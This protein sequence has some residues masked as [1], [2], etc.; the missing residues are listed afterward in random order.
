MD[1]SRVLTARSIW[2]FDLAEL[3]PRGRRVE[4]V[5][6]AVKSRYSFQNAALEGN[7]YI[8]KKGI[9]LIAGQEIDIDSLE[10]FDDGVVLN[11]RSDTKDSD[12]FLE[13]LFAWLW[14][15]C[16]LGGAGFSTKPKRIYLS[17][18]VVTLPR[19]SID[20]GIGSL[21]DL[22]PSVSEM[23]G[24]PVDMIETQSI[25]FGS[26]EKRNLLTIDRRRGEPF[27]ANKYFSTATMTTDKHLA[28]LAKVEALLSI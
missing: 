6:E 27:Q 28:L 26:S 23:S 15:E 16:G 21:L 13:D 8:F 2:L 17:E 14:T 4:P 5:F 25:V 24:V 11:T 10:V 18:V 12:A 22:K 1:L 20:S 19:V 3:N 7:G 9:F